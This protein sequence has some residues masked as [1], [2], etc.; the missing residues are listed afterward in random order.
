MVEAQ[1]V[2]SKCKKSKI[3]GIRMEKK[4]GVWVTTWAFP[5]S[6]KRAETEKYSSVELKGTFKKS[7]EYN[8]C[9]Y[10]GTKQF[11]L[12][13][14]CSKISCY[15]NETEIVCNWCGNKGN[16]VQRE[17]ISLNGGSF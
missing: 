11:V 3:Y 1:V 9:P 17:Q 8:G 2:I 7:D 15:N 13:E 10:C 5:V 4:D 14:K 16:V 6:E 12:C